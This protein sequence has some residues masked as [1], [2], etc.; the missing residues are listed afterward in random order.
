M[1]R[2]IQLLRADDI[3]G[4]WAI[5]PTPAKDNSSDWRSNDTVDIDEVARMVEGLISS[6]INGILSLGTLG[7]GA[8]LTW[9]EKKVFMS[10][11]V[12]TARG[13][14][15]VFVGS[16]ALNTRDVIEQARFAKD[17]RAQGT[18]LGLPM[19]CAPSTDVAVQFYR[20]VAEA[21]PELNIAIYANSEAFKYDFPA[22]FW[23]GVAEIPQVVTAKYIGIGSLLQHLHAVKGRIKLLP[24][25]F[26]YYAAARIDDG[27]DAFWTSGAVCGPTVAIHLRD[28]V[29]E[30]RQTGDWATARAW[31][32]R[33]APTAAPLFPDGSFKKFSM[34][35]IALEKERINAAGWMRA[36]PVR[37]PYHLV[38]EEY[39][40]GARKSGQLWAELHQEILREHDE[41]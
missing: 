9:N 22:P 6:G 39:L 27:I 31:H 20:D 34:Y 12:E 32:A 23:A 28:L 19:W 7:E 36:G 2:V 30:A 10:T 41:G 15:P 24:L 16:T 8:T 1:S 4:T 3:K 29:A 5:V 37:P 14:I 21:V 38:P 33:M 17:I 18:M 40:L 11:L 25:D 13:R 26:D 35:N